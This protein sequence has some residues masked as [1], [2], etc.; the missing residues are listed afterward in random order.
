MDFVSPQ[1]FLQLATFFTG[2][3]KDG[4]GIIVRVDTGHPT[5]RVS[6]VICAIIL[7]Y[8]LDTPYPCDLYMYACMNMCLL[9]WHSYGLLG[10]TCSLFRRQTESH[11][12][13]SVGC[14]PQEH[15]CFS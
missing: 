9:I 6:V 4:K 12:E 8:L 5:Y 2:A 10:S 13:N 3:P 15:M 7:L 1:I 14:N 11:T